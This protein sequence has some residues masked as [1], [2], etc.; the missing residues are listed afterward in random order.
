MDR[1]F[2]YDAENKQTKVE[3]LSPG[4][5]TVT[6]TIGEYTYDGDGKRVKKYVPSTGETTIFVYDAAGKQIAEYSTV[7][8][9]TEDA[10][11]AYLTQDDLGTPRIN[12]DANGGVISRSDYL[13]Y[14]E[15]LIAQ[16]NRSS[17]EKYQGDTVRQEFT[18]YER[19]NET[20]LDFAQARMYGNSHGRFT[21]PD[22]YKIVAE[23][24]AEQNR[25]KAA[26][27]LYRYISRPQ[28]WNQYV[29]AV[30]NP[31]KYTDP[32]G[33]KVDLT[34]ETAKERVAALQRL[35]NILGEER[36][37]LVTVSADGR[38]VSLS[39]E[40]VAA[41][42][43][44]GNDVDNKDFS[45]GFAEILNSSQSVE[46]Q[47]TESFTNKHGKTFS[48]STTLI[49]GGI[50]VGKE[51]SSTGNIQIFVNPRAGEAAT[52]FDALEPR[53]RSN[54]GK[55]LVSTNAMVDAHEFGES[56]PKLQAAQGPAM[57][58]SP[59]SREPA[60]KTFENAIRSRTNNSQRR[61]NH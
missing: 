3:T 7:V 11:V 22:P 20:E 42:Q 57:G 47:V 36:F 53:R 37:K 50:T 30:N 14:G 16:G 51:E 40:N 8:A 31:L 58:A 61:A 12:T 32:S 46:F 33:E 5:D 27:M 26:A 17:A 60:W 21:S 52:N 29:Y 43:K 41:L 24:Q 48:T 6:G 15:E 19:D 18:G 13:P 54:D 2:T 35:R 55:P 4:T 44:I 38:S 34:G 23:V 59:N 56:L 28:Q 25:E 49:P 45:L 39:N 9:D 10:K 1:K